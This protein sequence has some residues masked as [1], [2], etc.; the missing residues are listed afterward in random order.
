[1]SSQSLRALHGMS[2]LFLRLVL[3]LNDYLTLLVISVITA[4]GLSNRQLSRIL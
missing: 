3:A 1:M 4:E 2:F